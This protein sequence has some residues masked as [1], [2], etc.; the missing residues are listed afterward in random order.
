MGVF[1]Q[2]AI[3][4]V[5]DVLQEFPVSQSIRTLHGLSEGVENTSFFVE[6]DK[7]RVILTLIERRVTQSHIDLA[8]EM[9]DLANLA[10]LS[11]PRIFRTK[12]GCNHARIDHRVW[13]MQ[14]YK[15][16]VSVSAFGNKYIE[17][18]GSILGR[19]HTACSKAGKTAENSI[20]HSQW[21]GL[22]AALEAI[23]GY[24]RAVS[25]RIV[26]DVGNLDAE[27]PSD[28]PSGP[29]HGDFFASNILAAAGRVS[30]IDFLLCCNDLY[31]YDLAL[32]I[33]SFGFDQSNVLREDYA[34]L[35]L[36]GYMQERRLGERELQ[37]LP[38]LMKMAAIRIILTRALDRYRKVRGGS[39]EA[40]D[41][42]QFAQRYLQ[43]G[44]AEWLRLL[45]G[46]SPARHLLD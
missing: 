14:S 29:V 5:P 15:D 2:I 45:Q 9:M 4:R 13:I 21:P 25:D 28:L 23:G 44:D 6:T 17:Q 7:E 40:K 20:G 1:T 24:E 3:Q 18:S 46:G 16:G 22:V 36:K 30:V 34:S 12:D 27:W 11:A 10:D 37:A 41:P 8:E 32:A 43:I 26:E 31:A 39:V 33:T 19:L 35:F 42:E 38:Y